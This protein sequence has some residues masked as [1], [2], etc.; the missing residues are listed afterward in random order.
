MS[1]L[2][3]TAESRERHAPGQRLDIL[4][5]LEYCRQIA[6]IW[7]VED[8]QEVRPNLDKAQAWKVLQE[9]DRCKDASLGITWDTLTCAAECLYP[10]KG[11]AP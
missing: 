3:V 2:F 10:E 7:G 11:G 4:E 1:P 9:V 8:V 6:H 5:L